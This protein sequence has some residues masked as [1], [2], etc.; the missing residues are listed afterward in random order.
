MSGEIEAEILA[1]FGH[2]LGTRPRFGF[3]KPQVLIR[4]ILAAEQCR[5]PT[6]PLSLCRIG[7]GQEHVDIGKQLPAVLIQAIKRAR[8]DQALQLPRVH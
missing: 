6:R 8:S 4:G 2:L 7:N 5:L 1:L 3:L